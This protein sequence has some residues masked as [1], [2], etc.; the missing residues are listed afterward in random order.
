MTRRIINPPITIF[1]GDFFRDK[2]SPWGNFT[3]KLS[4]AEE[5]AG[6]PFFYMAF[7][8]CENVYMVTVST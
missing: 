5:T 8:C 2:C 7:A 1:W 4:S 6:Q 3:S